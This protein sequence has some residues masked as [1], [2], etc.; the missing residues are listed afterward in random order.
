AVAGAGQPELPPA[1]PKVLNDRIACLH[2][3]GN[4]RKPEDTR[5][6]IAW[7]RRRGGRMRR[8]DGACSALKPADGDDR[9]R[10]LVAENADVMK[11]ST[12]HH[13]GIYHTS[14]VDHTLRPARGP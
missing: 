6:A 7:P 10:R 9:L 2:A 12:I 13:E 3:L 5:R 14:G 4:G 11:A 8:L 1:E